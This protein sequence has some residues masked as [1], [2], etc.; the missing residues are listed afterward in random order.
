MRMTELVPTE[1]LFY[2]SSIYRLVGKTHQNQFVDI[3]GGWHWSAFSARYGR[4]RPKRILSLQRRHYGI[5]RICKFSRSVNVTLIQRV[6][7]LREFTYTLYANVTQNEEYI[8]SFVHLTAVVQFGKSFTS[9]LMLVVIVFD[10]LSYVPLVIQISCGSLLGPNT[11][12]QEI[13][14]N[15]ACTGNDEVLWIRK[16][17]MNWLC[18]T[19]CKSLKKECISRLRIPK[20]PGSES[21][22]HVPPRSATTTR[23]IGGT[24]CRAGYTHV[25]PL[26]R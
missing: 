14:I 9:V 20:G 7:L 6:A 2:H 18:T 21:G 26:V 23:H 25:R 24:Q 4:H 16:V 10:V 11:V 1:H 5:L 22:R 17:G 19:K 15:H 3:L 8:A 12:R 13:C